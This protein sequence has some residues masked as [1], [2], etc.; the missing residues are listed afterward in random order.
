LQ[1]YT[2]MRKNDAEIHLWKNLGVHKWKD[3][4]ETA[5]SFGRQKLGLRLGAEPGAGEGQA[6]KAGK[7]GNERKA[8]P[9]REVSNEAGSKGKSRKVALAPQP[10]MTREQ[11]LRTLG[12]EVDATDAEIELALAKVAPGK[13][14]GLNGSDHAIAAK[15][16]EAR[17]ILSSR[18]GHEPSPEQ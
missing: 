8:N 11:A 15:I 12:L 18:K 1:Q 17:H 9:Q 6:G 4:L 3:R 2:I 16:D 14:Q 10:A 13:G 5:K 7:A